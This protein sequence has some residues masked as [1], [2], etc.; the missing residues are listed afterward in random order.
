MFA[1]PRPATTYPP[2][3]AD[4]GDKGSLSDQFALA[5]HTH[6]AKTLVNMAQPTTA[7]DGTYTWTYPVAY[8]AGTVPNVQG[9]VQATAGS[10]DVLNAQLDGV[11]TNTQ[12]KFRVTRTVQSVVALLGLTILS[13]P[14]SI[15]AQKLHL[16]AEA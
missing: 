7:T 14:T 13:I 8:P 15:G 12:A 1:V 6:A 3:V 10:T 16:R 9:N 2:S 5:D 11:P 4:T